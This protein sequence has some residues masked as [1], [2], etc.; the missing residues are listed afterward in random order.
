MQVDRNLER[1]DYCTEGDMVEK[2]GGGVNAVCE[3]KTQEYSGKGGDE[4]KEKW[5]TERGVERG[6]GSVEEG[7]GEV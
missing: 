5:V 6:R 2:V 1:W 7:M 3:E 4:G